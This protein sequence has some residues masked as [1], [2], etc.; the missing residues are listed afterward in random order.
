MV[1]LLV[2]ALVLTWAGGL[3]NVSLASGLSYKAGLGYDYFSQQY[4]LDS[5][6]T[7]GVDSQLVRWSYNSI[8]LNDLKGFVEARYSPRKSRFE[9]GGSHEQTNNQFRTRL[10]SIYRPKFSRFRL[11]SRGELEWR[12]RYRGAHNPGDSYVDGRGQG[13]LRYSLSKVT[14]LWGEIRGEFVRFATQ[15]SF[16]HNYLRLG[17]KIGAELN[18]GLS[19]LDLAFFAQQRS[20]GDSAQMNYACTGFDG[21][22]FGLYNWGDLDFLTHFENRRY[23]RTDSVN[24]YSRLEINGRS[25][26]LLGKGF[27]LRPELLVE[28]NKYRKSDVVNQDY[29]RLQTALMTGCGILG[30][31][32]ILAGPAVDILSQERDSMAID[33]AYTES[34]ARIEFDYTEPSKVF[35]VFQGN[36]GYRTMRTEDRSQS[37]FRYFRLSIMGDVTISRRF[38]LNTLLGAEWEWHRS[39][40]NNTRLVLFSS[41]LTY[42]F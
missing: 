29:W 19:T 38:D 4:F 42:S 15:T 12:Q 13:K 6:R 16:A 35:G 8:Y 17:Q 2:A 28:Q 24:D 36:F 1:R 30:P 3:G 41:S 9:L 27:F 14:T 7:A 33:Q 32:S 11:D 10:Y 5:L 40:S 21:S 20:V 22:F 37:S 18:L 25:K 26:V 23:N 39:N 31:A 34:G